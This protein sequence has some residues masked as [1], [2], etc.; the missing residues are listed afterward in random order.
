MEGC[1][2]ARQI[3]NAGEMNGFLKARAPLLQGG[4]EFRDGAMQLKA[5]YAPRLDRAA[6]ETFAVDSFSFGRAKGVDLAASELRAS[7]RS[8][9]QRDRPIADTRRSTMLNAQ[10]DSAD[11]AGPCRV[12][13]SSRS[14]SSR[15]PGKIPVAAD[16]IHRPWG[17]GGGADQ[18]ARKAAKLMEEDLKVSLAGGEFAGRDRQHRDGEAARRR[19]RTVIRFRS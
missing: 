17:P 12:R 2:A 16:R 6:L 4:L 1:I 14:R 13:A 11:L 3:D 9:G 19:R 15:R 10:F 5:G 7:V 8:P 18:L